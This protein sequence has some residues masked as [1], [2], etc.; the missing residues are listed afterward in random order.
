MTDSNEEIEV[1]ANVKLNIDL[2]IKSIGAATGSVFED[3]LQPARDAIKAEL[4]KAQKDHATAKARLALLADKLS[5]T[6]LNK[7]KLAGIKEFKAVAAAHTKATVVIGSGT[8]Y[9]VALNN[10]RA[11][12]DDGVI[13]G[14]LV[15][16]DVIEKTRYNSATYHDEIMEMNVEIPFTAEMQK[17]V[18][19]I[20]NAA[21]TL[22]TVRE[23]ERTITHLLAQ[24]Q[25]VVERTEREI[26]MQL[27]SGS[28]ATR[29]T[30]VE[31]GNTAIAQ[32]LGG[33]IKSL[34]AAHRKLLEAPK[35]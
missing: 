33:A 1:E 13:I 35:S 7:G 34:P 22:E 27:M 31:A 32:T 28:K 24:R 8:Q 26:T 23:H 4:E 30:L 3:R 16:Q 18:K 12:A 21:K 2:D 20:N 5:A 19:D 15:V 14:E 11:N 25:K 6:S 29:S 9:E 10:P 17:V